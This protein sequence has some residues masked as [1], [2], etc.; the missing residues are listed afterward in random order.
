MSLSGKQWHS[1]TKQE[2]VIEVW[3]ALDCESVG[4]R[5]L[6]QIQEELRQKFGDG[7]AHSPAAIARIVA[8]EGAVLRHPE[9]FESDLRWR[10]QKLGHHG[11]DSDLAFSSFAEALESFK[12]LEDSRREIN[13]DNQR[14]EK[15]RELVVAA[16]QDLL[17]TARSKII[18]AEQRQQAKEI[19]AWLAVWLESPQL[20][21]DWLE[22]RRRFATIH[23]KVSN[24]TLTYS[25]RHA[26]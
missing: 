5:E 11:V 22:L 10:E 16:R 6:E 2:L 26:N 18:A 15:L 12:R 1:R 13:N 25:P 21:P 23:Q 9:V 24:L 20:F 8:D 7:A 4:R 14:L 19:A 3:E 17:L